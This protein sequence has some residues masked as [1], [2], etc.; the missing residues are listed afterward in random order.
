MKPMLF[1]NL[2]HPQM[3]ALWLCLLLSAGCKKIAQHFIPNDYDQVNLVADVPGFGAAHIDSN[4]VNAWGIAAAPSGPIWISA[5]ETGVSPIYDKTGATLRPP[6]AI[7]TPTDSVGGAPTGIVFNNT[8][9]FAIWSGKQSTPSRFIFATEDGTLAAWGGGNTATIVADRSAWHTVYKGL[10][11]AQDGGNNY[12]YATDFRGGKVDVFDK[13]FKYVTGKPFHD[14]HI[15]QGYAPFNIR[16]M[17]GYLYVTYAKQQLPE[18]EDDEA[19]AGNG[20]VDVFW[21]NGMLVKR[22]AS[23]GALNSP[24]GIVMAAPG[25]CA[26]KDVILVG[27]F[28]DG[29]INM[30]STAGN[31]LGPLKMGWQPIVIHGLWAL[32][33]NVPMA[34]PA[35]LFF[36]AGPDRE[37]H[38][39]FGY[40][41][42]N[43]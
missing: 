29:K 28:G 2:A 21:P 19:G 32:E 35:L 27:N 15:P 4:L 40:L 9:D 13:D 1:K 36:T 10:A 5:A 33:N 25:F 34:D 23:R 41:K 17:G 3:G 6:V 24:W 16:S 43:Q 20:Y 42:N 12:L 14:P 8:T 30:Y 26:T 37:E 11:L 18:K 7:P 31:F 38:G 22:F 39:L